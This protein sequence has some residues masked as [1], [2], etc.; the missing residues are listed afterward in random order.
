MKK[1]KISY[2]VVTATEDHTL[3][4]AR[5]MRQ[6]DVDEV[7][8]SG[9]LE[10]LEALLTSMRVSKDPKAGLADGK[11]VCM[12]GVGTPTLTSDWGMPWLLTADALPRHAVEFLRRNR[13]YVADIRNEYRLLLNFADARNIMALRWLA[14]LGFEIEPAVAFGVEGMPFHPF[15]MERT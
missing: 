15:R 8:A 3:E 2:K 6:A 13:E 1:K 9:H 4:M 7:W 12:Y 5:V 14:W 10:P 11:V